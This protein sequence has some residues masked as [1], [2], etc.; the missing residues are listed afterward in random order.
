MERQLLRNTDVELTDSNVVDYLLDVAHDHTAGVAY[1]PHDQLQ[2]QHQ[3]PQPDCCSRS[4]DDRGA[5]CKPQQVWLAGYH[6]R[7]VWLYRPSLY[8][9]H[10]YH[11]WLYRPSWSGYH[12]YHV[13]LYR[14]SCSGYHPYHV[15]LYRPPCLATIPILPGHT[16]HP[17]LAIIP[18][19]SGFT[20]HPCLAIITILSGCHLIL[21]GLFPSFCR[22]SSL[23]LFTRLQLWV[24][25]RW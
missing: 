15:W 3:P 6:P 24:R 23:R 17:C 16:L 7:P 25:M 9:Y 4:D 14:P 8:G 12:P 2:L 19:L 20:V 18:V 10:P 21:P 1:C 22:S 13:W 5:P 11:V